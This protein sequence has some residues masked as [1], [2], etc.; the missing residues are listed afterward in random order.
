[1]IS[2]IK[3]TINKAYKLYAKHSKKCLS[4]IKKIAK[5]DSSK[6]VAENAKKLKV[7]HIYAAV[8]A[9]RYGLK[10]VYYR[11]NRFS[12]P[13]IKKLLH[14]GL[15]YEDIAKIMGCTKQNVHLKVNKK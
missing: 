10:H 3:M 2:L 15:T 12:V 8:L 14:T 7:S 4:I 6:T 13:F 5:W 1:M 9:K 11:D